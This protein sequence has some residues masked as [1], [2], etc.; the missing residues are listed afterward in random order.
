MKNL[1]LGVTV[2]LAD[3]WSFL[4]LSLDFVWLEFEELG[5]NFL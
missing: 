5:L 1:V 2:I 3:P 4:F